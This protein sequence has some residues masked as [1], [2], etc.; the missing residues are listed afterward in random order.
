MRIR[1]GRSPFFV[2]GAMMFVSQIISVSVTISADIVRIKVVRT[3][4][5]E[6]LRTWYNIAYEIS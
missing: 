2:A 5:I 4:S 3:P 1:Y 6:M